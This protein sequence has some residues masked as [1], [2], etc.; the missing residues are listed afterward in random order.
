MPKYYGVTN[1]VPMPTTPEG[2]KHKEFMEE[3]RDLL[4]GAVSRKTEPVWTSPEVGSWWQDGNGRVVRVTGVTD[5]EV[6]FNVVWQNV[7]E[8][9]CTQVAD[10]THVRYFVP[11]RPRENARFRPLDPALLGRMWSDL[12]GLIRQYRQSMEEDDAPEVG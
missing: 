1:P 2:K 8:N 5:T 11:N 9:G 3:L 10:S 6:Y 12:D 7:L 4:H